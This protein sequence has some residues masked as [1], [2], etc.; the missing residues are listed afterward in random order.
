MH[1][2]TVQQILSACYVHKHTVQ[3]V[4]FCRPFKQRNSFNLIEAYFNKTRWS[5]CTDISTAAS[6]MTENCNGPVAQT[7]KDAPDISC[8]HCSIHRQAVTAKCMGEG[9]NQA[10]DNAVKTSNFNTSRPSN[11][12][13]FQVLCEKMGSARSLLSDTGVS[14]LSR[15]TSHVSAYSW[16]PSF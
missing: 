12:R 10:L 15:G 11:S 6:S 13:I 7:K 2:H 5:R 9:P 14:W 4:L 1:E 16:N 8:T 3:Q